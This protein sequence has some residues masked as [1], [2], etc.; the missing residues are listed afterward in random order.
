[1]S[2]FPTPALAPQDLQPHVLE[3]NRSPDM[4]VSGQTSLPADVV[5]KKKV[6][7][8]MAEVATARTALV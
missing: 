7:R 5:A 6:A 4:S 8:D 3:V 2:S 1:M